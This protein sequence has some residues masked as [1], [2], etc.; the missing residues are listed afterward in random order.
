[1]RTFSFFIHTASSTV[2]ALH[3]ES[4]TDEETARAFARSALAESSSRLMVEVREEERLLFTLDRNG[5]S[6]ASSPERRASRDHEQ[7]LSGRSL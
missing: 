4:L 1:M 6:W 3:I 2:P 5:A 7:S